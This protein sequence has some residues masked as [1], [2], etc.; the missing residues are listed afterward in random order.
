MEWIS[1]L[2][3]SK[4]VLLNEYAKELSKRDIEVLSNAYERVL[5]IKLNMMLGDE[6]EAEKVLAEI[7][8]GITEEG[9]MIQQNL[10]EGRVYDMEIKKNTDT[11][12]AEYLKA[13]G[14]GTSEKVIIEDLSFNY[15]TLTKTA[16]KNIITEYKRDNNDKELDAAIED[17]FPKEE[18]K[19]EKIEKEIEKKAEKEVPKTMEKKIIPDVSYFAERRAEIEKEREYNLKRL[20]ESINEWIEGMEKEVEEI[21][22]RIADLR[23]IMY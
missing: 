18:E 13:K 21:K 15:H 8:E 19:E 22:S 6:L 9:K 10:K 3:P 1:S 2:S 7:V 17:I 12:I 23:E 4:T 5:R 20:E 14:K 16:I 11:I